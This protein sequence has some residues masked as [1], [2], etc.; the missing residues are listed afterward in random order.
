MVEED[1]ATIAA[2]ESGDPDRARRVVR[3]DPDSER[4]TVADIFAIRAGS[5]SSDITQA[6]LDGASLCQ[7]VRSPIVGWGSAG[8]VSDLSEVLVMGCEPAA[9]DVG[10]AP[11]C[12]TGSAPIDGSVSRRSCR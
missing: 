11:V 5:A 12:P 4:L 9:L 7:G 10:V 3:G 2:L 1:A 6:R 8:P